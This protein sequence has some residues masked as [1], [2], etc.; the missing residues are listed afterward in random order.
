[1]RG[2]ILNVE[3][4]RFDKILKSEAIAMLITAL[5]TG[6][7]PESFDPSKVRYHKIII[8][9]DADVD[10][11]HIR[12]L[13]LTFF[14]RQMPELI[15]RGNLYIA[16]PPLYKVKKGKKEQYL[17]DEQAMQ[18]YLLESGT[19][20]IYLLAGENPH[21]IEEEEILTLMEEIIRFQEWIT[22]F[23]RRSDLRLV[24]AVLSA[25]SLVAAD[26]EDREKVE[27]A[28]KAMVEYLQVQSPQIFPLDLKVQED[29]EHG[30]FEIRANTIFNGRGVRTVMNRNFMQSAMFTRIQQLAIKLHSF[31][32]APYR[33]MKSS[34]EEE[35]EVRSTLE[36]ILSEV[37]TLARKGQGI[38]RYKGL[39]E[40]N[41]SQLWETTMDPD[42]RTMLQV[43]V[44]DA[45]EADQLFTILMG[46]DVEPR[47]AFIMENAL[48]V[49]NLDI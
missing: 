3:K 35:L 27:S 38:Q 46:D 39:G 45:V 2:K 9:T 48:N 49:N 30:A 47:R 10:G 34:T 25:T 36:S 24:D 31:G 4:A 28:A 15:E 5:G 18:R 8:M 23:S 14:Y 32:G 29:V 22:P 44:E 40:M 13:L 37:M 21:R 33:L 7:G 26:M 11:Y 16:Q 20:G 43:R 41:P 17:G 1:L 6:I 12:T 42:T 19:N